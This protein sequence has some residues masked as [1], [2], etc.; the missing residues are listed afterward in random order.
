M[1]RVRIGDIVHYVGDRDPECSCC[2][3]IVTSVRTREL[4]DL[5]VMESSPENQWDTEHSRKGTR[6]ITKVNYDKEAR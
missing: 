3:A 2:V 5:R 6:L 1:L 4:V